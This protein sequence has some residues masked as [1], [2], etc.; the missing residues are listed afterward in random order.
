MAEMYQRCCPWLVFVGFITVAAI[1][2]FMDGATTIGGGGTA[3]TGGGEFP[4]GGV[5]GGV[6]A[7]VS[8]FLFLVVWSV[9]CA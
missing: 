3:V 5:L 4:I 6:V 7:I 8:D 9:N 2:G 1:V